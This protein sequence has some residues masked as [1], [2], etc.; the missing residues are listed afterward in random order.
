MARTV[1]AQ[2][3]A[4]F[5][6]EEL[7][8]IP[9]LLLQKLLFYSHAASLVWDNLPLFLNRI[10]AWVNGPVVVDIWR[11]HSYEWIIAE[12]N[13]N[14]KA[15]DEDNKAT[16]RSILKSYANWEPQILANLTHE[17]TPWVEARRGLNPGQRGC[18]EITNDAIERYYSEAWE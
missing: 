2:D 11:E 17:E 1:T 10:E 12:T 3:V 6:I 14:S 5:I 15:L 18:N 16:V 9:Q 4:K 7:G 13:G 8:P